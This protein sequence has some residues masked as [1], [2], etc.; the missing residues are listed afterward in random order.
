MFPPNMP[1]MELYAGDDFTETL[2]FREAG[3]PVDLTGWSGWEAEWRAR[4]KHETFTVDA[5]RED[6]G[7]ITLTLTAAQT[8]VMRGHGSWDLQAMKGGL[9]RTWVSG[10]TVWRED[11]TGRTDD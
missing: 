11:V 5:S 4:G 8:R 6:E 9:T 2:R 10:V 3:E 1:A 7:L